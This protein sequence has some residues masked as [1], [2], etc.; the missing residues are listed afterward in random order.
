MEKLEGEVLEKEEV[1]ENIT[2]NE[3]VQ[4]IPK[5]KK[6]GRKKKVEQVEEI[7]N[8]EDIDFKNNDTIENEENNN[9]SKLDDII[10]EDKKLNLPNIVYKKNGE[11]KKLSKK[12]S[13]GIIGACIIV[14]GFLF[15][16]MFALANSGNEKIISGVN[17]KGINVSGMTRDE[18]Y[19]KVQSAIDAKLSTA[20]DLVYKDSR[21]TIIP[22]QFEASFDVDNSVNTAFERG[23]SGNI[24]RNNYEILGSLLFKVNINPSFS[25]NEEAIDKLIEEIQTNLP[26]KMIEPSY[27]IEDENLIITRGVNGI[28]INSDGLKLK[29]ISNINNLNSKNEDIE[30]PVTDATAKEIDIEAI[31]NEIYKEAKDA[32]F[33]KEPFTVYPH[34]VGVD[35][36]ISIDEAKELL[37][38]DKES[39]TIPL[40]ITKPNV[41]TDKIGTE[42]FPDLLASYSTTYS[43]KNVNRSTNIALASKKL[44]GTVI[45]PGEV[46]SYNSTIGKRTPQ[47]GFKPAAVY[48]GGEVTTDYG[49]GICQ[50]SSTLYNSVL[51]SNLQ[52]VERCNHGFNPGYVPAGRDATVSWGGPDFKFKNSRNYPIRL[53]CS[54]TGGTITVKIYGV[55]EENDYEVEIQ[56]WVTSY[57]PYQTINRQDGSLAAGQTKVIESG[58]NG[59]RSVA[60]RVLKQNGAVVSKT[61]LSTDTYNP[62]NRI[63][64][65]GASGAA[66]TTENQPAEPETPENNDNTSSGN[67]SSETPNDN[68]GNN[69]NTGDD[70]GNNSNTGDDTGL[71][72]NDDSNPSVVVTP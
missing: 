23:R 69:S 60:Y 14:F 18:A 57:I 38:E 8:S 19:Q 17:I 29:I 10:K 58:S 70:N 11:I 55:K 35:F 56:S 49:G 12:L 72:N 39:Y 27:Y 28:V 54:G 48:L 64:A 32:Y 53:S 42:A 25:Y 41:T 62:H 61:L 6:K 30:I 16:T 24:F 22:E 37:K 21:T 20:F 36:A 59:C 40:K 46:F 43:T 47:A 7:V 33:T 34:E 9:S 51:L 13:M 63:V 1:M 65:V 15:S 44:N 45:M 66:T 68:T 3:E 67:N 2:E 50:V 31:H 26:D 71:G 52:I 4:E 5:P